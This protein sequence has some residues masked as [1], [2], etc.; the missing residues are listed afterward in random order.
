MLRLMLML[1]REY[2]YL[3][4]YYNFLFFSPCL[5]FLHF[6]LHVN[7]FSC[8]DSYI[9]KKTNTYP[10]PNS[11]SRYFGLDTRVKSKWDCES[12]LSTYS[13]TDNLPTVIGRRRRQKQKKKPLIRLHHRTG[14]PLLHEEDEDEEEGQADMNIINPREVVDGECSA[15]KDKFDDSVYLAGTARNRNETKEERKRRKALVKEQRRKRR[16]EKKMMKGAFKQERKRQTKQ[17]AHM[18]R[19]I[20]GQRVM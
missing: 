13:T 10:Y 5:D 15:S 17:Q 3:E 14:V 18:K 12:V 9:T 6:H 1:R 7:I 11:N 2:L 20:Q 19:E 4:Y 16:E 8:N